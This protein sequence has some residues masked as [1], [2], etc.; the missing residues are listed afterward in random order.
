MIDCKQQETEI[1]TF[2]LLLTSDKKNESSIDR[3][4]MYSNLKKLLIYYCFP[5]CSNHSQIARDEPLKVD[6]LSVKEDLSNVV[7]HQFGWLL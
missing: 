4:Y 2:V 7:Y 3:G 1:E 6:Y 5:Y